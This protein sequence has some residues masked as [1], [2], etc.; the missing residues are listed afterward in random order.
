MDGLLTPLQHVLFHL[1][2]V[3][4]T[5]VEIFGF[6]TGALCVYLVVI[7]NIW[8]WPIGIA[9]NAFFLLLFLDSGLYADS[10]LQ[11]AFALLSVYGWYQWLT[12]G[13]Q[14]NDLPVRRSRATETAAQ[15]AAALTGTI[16]V[17]LILARFTDS[18][19]PVWDG[20]VLALSLV[21]TYGQALKLIESWWVWIAV[22]AISVPLYAVKGLYLTAFLYAGFLALCVMGLRAWTAELRHP[23]VLAR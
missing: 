20:A 3:D 18:T 6:G 16:A 23:A 17:S 19:V 14:T 11:I 7:Q 5:W 15:A 2:G 4:V 13:P 1:A 22:D 12:R 9:N 21:A 8:N 10:A